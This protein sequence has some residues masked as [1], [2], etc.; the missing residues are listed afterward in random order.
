MHHAWGIDDIRYLIFEFFTPRG[1]A[2]LAQT[3]NYFFDLATHELWKVIT[4]FSPFIFCL[5]P[6]FSRRPLQTADIKRLNF[7]S[8]KVRHISLLG[9]TGAKAIRL[10]FHDQKRR[11]KDPAKLWKDLWG[12]IA[13]LR[14]RSD[15]LPNIQSIRMD[16]VGEAILM[17]LMEISGSNITKIYMRAIHYKPEPF[18]S[19]FLDQLQCAPRLEYLFVK[20]G[21]DFVPPK[22]IIQSPLKHLRLDPRIHAGKF[23]Y[24]TL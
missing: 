2:H 20:D 5:P 1:L 17:P 18:I 16:D 24:L 3:C 8:S 23:E 14:P 13:K 7:Y 9:R 6:D 12:E 21:E 10:P 4:S 15:F 11:P 22:L 19:N